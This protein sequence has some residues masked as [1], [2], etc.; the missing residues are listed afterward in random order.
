MKKRRSIILGLLSFIVI[1]ALAFT[2]YYAVC[3]REGDVSNVKIDVSGVHNYTAEETN[4]AADAILSYFK[5]CDEFNYY[6]MDELYVVEDA[7]GTRAKEL[8]SNENVNNAL[9]FQSFIET[10]FIIGKSRLKLFYS[11]SPWIWVVTQNENGE[12]EIAA[13]EC[14]FS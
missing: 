11:E 8:A 5:G 6:R 7:V 4:A 12:W 1:V 2:A 3:K 9:R 14:G 10:G 13:N